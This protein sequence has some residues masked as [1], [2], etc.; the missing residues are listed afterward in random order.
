M[1]QG[2]GAVAVLVLACATLSLVGC[3]ADFKAVQAA[4]VAGQK[5]EGR[6]SAFSA[7]SGVCLEMRALGGRAPTDC[8]DVEKLAADWDKVALAMTAYAA[9][10]TALAQAKDVAVSDQVT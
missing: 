4:G 7:A 9:Q 10:L 3:P 1:W 2:R 6:A 8:A 5:I